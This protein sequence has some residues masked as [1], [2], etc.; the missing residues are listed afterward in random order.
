MNRGC[1]KTARVLSQTSPGRSKI[2][3]PE[4]PVLYTFVQHLVHEWVAWG[5]FLTPLGVSQF[6]HF[7]RSG[8]KSVIHRVKGDQL[9]PTDRN[10]QNKLSELLVLAFTKK[11]RMLCDKVAV[12]I[13]FSRLF[14]PKVN[15]NTF[16]SGTF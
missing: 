10:A 16:K 7:K 9:T 8:T 6:S 14:Y 4:Y 11:P 12:V 3:F 1:W 13:T 5:F 15:S 2:S